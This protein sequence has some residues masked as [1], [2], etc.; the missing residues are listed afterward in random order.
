M[1]FEYT[2]KTDLDSS[3]LKAA[4]Y[5]TVT[6][7]L[8]VEMSNGS[9]YAYTNVPSKIFAGIRQSISAGSYYN[10]N[11]QGQYTN[12]YG[13]SVWM[14][15]GIMEELVPV[16]EQKTFTVRATVEFEASVTASDLDEAV[17][18]FLES[19]KDVPGIKIKEV[20]V[21]FGE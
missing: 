9:S 10:R 3:W 7:E 11:I 1:Y 8:A 16:A 14:T 19:N 21:P 13:G 20:V 4:Y 5:N 6:G 15:Y 2:D 18:V 12:A 17:K